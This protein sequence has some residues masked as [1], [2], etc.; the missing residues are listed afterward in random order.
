MLKEE[1]KEIIKFSIFGVIQG[2]TQILKEIFDGEECL[3]KLESVVIITEN[4]KIQR[5]KYSLFS[6]HYMIQLVLWRGVKEGS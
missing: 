3:N 5:H 6:F 2:E 4:H 1:A